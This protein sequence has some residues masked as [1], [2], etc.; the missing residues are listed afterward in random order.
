MGEVHAVTDLTSGAQLALKRL[1]KGSGAAATALFEREFRTLAGLRHPRIVKVFDYGLDEDGAFYTM[2]L[3]EGRDLM[4][5]A[6]M[7]WRDTCACLRDVASILGVLHARHLVHRD[8]S[9]RNLW[10][11]KEGRLKMLDFGALSPFGK[12]TEIVGTPP[13]VAPEA[14]GRQAL[15]QRT[16]LFALGALGYWLLTSTHAYRAGSLAELPGLWERNPA[17]PS[18]LMKLLPNAAPDFP[19]E[20]DDLIGAL[21]RLDPHERPASTVDVIDTLNSIADLEPEADQLVVQSY[22]ESKAFVGRTRERALFSAHLA[23]AVLGEPQA[24][25][26]EGDEGLG[27]TRLLEEM[28]TTGRIAGAVVVSTGVTSSENPYGA[29]VALG[30]ALLRALPE[31]A[32]AAAGEHR[33]V[34]ARLAPR[35]ADSLHVRARAPDLDDPAAERVCRQS[36]LL[37]WFVEISRGR[38]LV[39]LVDDLHALDDES[40]AFI[41]TLARADAGSRLLVAASTSSEPG[42]ADSSA[43][44]SYRNAAARLRLPA[45]DALQTCELLRS[46]FGEAPYL[47]RLSARLHVIS[48]GNPRHC[49]MVAEHLVRTGAARYAEGAWA[50]PVE[51]NEA[52]LPRT[53]KAGLLARVDQLTSKQRELARLL[54]V[55]DRGSFTYAVCRALSGVAQ[56]AAD[57]LLEALVQQGILSRLDQGL[58]IAHPALRDALYAELAPSERIRVHRIIGAHLEET[59]SC[60]HVQELRA[61]VHFLRAGDIPRGEMLLLRAGKHHTRAVVENLRT[62]APMHEDALTCLQAAGQPTSSMLVPLQGLAA[63][64]YFVDQ[65][66]AVRH[67]EQA[68]YL[69]EE[70]LHLK[71]AR[72]LRPWLGARFSLLVALIVAGIGLRSNPRALSV[73]ETVRNLLASVASLVGTAA[74]RLDVEA[75]AR[76][77]AVIEPLTALGKEHAAN[78]VYQFCTALTLGTHEHTAEA[79]QRLASIIEWLRR[80]TVIEGLP[81]N[82]RQSYLAGAYFAMAV[83]EAF[84][85]GDGALALSDQLE[86]CGPL[87]AMQA[88]HVRAVYY[89]SRGDLE[90]TAHYRKRVDRQS[91]QLGNAWQAETWA[92]AEAAKIGFW[93]HDAV[94]VKRAARDLSHLAAEIPSFAFYARSAQGTYLLLRGRHAEA[95]AAIALPE[96]QAPCVGWTRTCGIVASAYNGLGEHE[97]ARTLCLKVLGRLTAED[98]EFVNACLNVQVELAIANAAL[99]R[100]DEAES[101]VDALLAQHRLAGWPLILGYLHQARARVA[102]YRC[103]FQSTRLHLGEMERWYLSSR[104]PSLI[105]VV[106]D[107]RRQLGAGS[108]RPGAEPR[109]HPS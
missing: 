78:L 7:G 4:G 46:V 81:D 9:P 61:S 108:E 63:A 47:E 65:R 82:I 106:Q 58:R 72:R 34:L 13:F 38:S 85:C 73:R 74:A 15:D 84:K 3:L 90:R 53:L 70:L 32:F 103:D 107:T 97:R 77:T 57:S 71:L 69:V 99:G 2:E 80:G 76:F 37:S 94:A 23:K 36:A 39:V 40:Q 54:S 79:H 59:A 33:S 51:L 105:G 87:H 18:S 64:G 62:T 8:L 22:L 60:D 86:R 44:H 101:S 28:A 83:R 42:E 6:P 50:L 1:F 88:D 56:E 93:T 14:L 89:A 100:F 16:D 49:L 26:I 104:I 29:A 41:G 27:R 20:L 35:L 17:R 31:A 67:G 68:V 48:Q 55:P 19:S 109:F 5:A 96:D 91:L 45:L 75:T 95:L 25:L 102:H 21:L 43:L 24:L 12:P 98:L 10:R 66:Y 30:L 52:G 92:P 11:T